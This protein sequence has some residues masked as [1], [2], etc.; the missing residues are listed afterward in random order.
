[1]FVNPTERMI[2]ELMAKGLGT[3]Q[4]AAQSGFSDTTVETYRNRMYK[5]LGVKNGCELVANAIRNGII[6]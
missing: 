5:R 4:I 1:M 6:K 3:K 2:I